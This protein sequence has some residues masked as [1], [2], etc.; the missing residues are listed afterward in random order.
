MLGFVEI[1]LGNSGIVSVRVR[2]LS[3]APA[4]FF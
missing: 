3:L 4:P 2:P 1:A